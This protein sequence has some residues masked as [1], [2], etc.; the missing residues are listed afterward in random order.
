MVEAMFDRVLRKAWLETELLFLITLFSLSA[1][2]LVI[3]DAGIALGIE[4]YNLTSV[5]A[6]A[7]ELV[8]AVV[9]LSISTKA[10]ME[11]NKFRRKHFRTI[12]LLRHERL[13][14]EQ[15]KGEATELVRDLVAFYRGYYRRAI[16]VLG[17]AIA[18]G[19]SIIVAASIL[20]AYGYMSFWE[21]VFRWIL[22]SA[23]LLTAS[24]FYVYVHR[25][26]G[27]K[28]LRIR[29]AEKGLSEMLGGPIEA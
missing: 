25:S 3:A 14:E 28:L 1:S 19:L 22:S 29:D 23:M 16:A 2:S 7:L 21:A 12:F 9:W 27:R 15:K 5:A 17:L 13:K 20:V 24:G 8:F 11:I 6:R 18:A 10:I 26:W 4:K